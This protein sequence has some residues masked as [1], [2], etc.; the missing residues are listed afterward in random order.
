MAVGGGDVLEW[1]CG[2]WFCGENFGGGGV[3]GGVCGFSAGAGGA[4]G[5]GGNGEGKGLLVEEAGRVW[6]HP[7]LVKVSVP[8]SKESL[9]GTQGRRVIQVEVVNPASDGEEEQ[10]TGYKYGVR[11]QE[12]PFKPGHEVKVAESVTF[13]EHWEKEYRR[14]VNAKVVRK[15]KGVVELS[16]SSMLWQTVST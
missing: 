7:G 8:G 2:V 1:A 9:E 15:E 13:A 3:E 5:G 12:W 16:L 4:A 14:T 6:E 10:E 11:E